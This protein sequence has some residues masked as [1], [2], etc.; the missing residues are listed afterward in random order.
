MDKDVIERVEHLIIEKK[1]MV[2]TDGYQFFNG[3]L[4]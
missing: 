2:M 4:E 1:L 3:Y